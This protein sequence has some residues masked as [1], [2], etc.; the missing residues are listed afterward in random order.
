MKR[1]ISVLMMLLFIQTAL[2]AAEKNI[3]VTF[4]AQVEIGQPFLVSIRSESEIDSVTISW[5]EKE[6]VLTGDNGTFNV[7]LGTDLKNA[8]TGT[9]ELRISCSLNGQ[10]LEEKRNIHLITRKYPRENLKV[11][12]EKLTPPASLSE[13][14]KREA[15]LGREAIQT[16]T[17]GSAPVL[18]LFKPVPGGYSSV[19]GKSRYL[20]GQFKGRHGGLDMR[21]ARGSPIKATSSGTVVLTGDFW[22]AGKCIYIDHGAGLISFYCH[23]SKVSKSKGEK[24]KRGEVIG[25]SGK[26]GRVTGPHLHFSVSWRGEFFD[27]APLL[28]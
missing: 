1:A 21:A 7:L 4:P 25:L 15:A 24:V 26:S 16:N 18:P 9:S 22:F 6:C 23:M 19:Y 12:P 28:K 14:I 5:Q 13:R 11:S 17:P 10:L 8:G 3:T 20:N 2:Y 27:P